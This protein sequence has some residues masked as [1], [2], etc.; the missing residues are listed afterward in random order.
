MKKLGRDAVRVRDHALTRRL[1]ITL[2]TSAA[3]I[4][5]GIATVEALAR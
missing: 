1:A 3:A 5:W 2:V 4:A